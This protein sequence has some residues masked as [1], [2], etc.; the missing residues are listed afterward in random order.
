MPF[1]FLMKEVKET[2]KKITQAQLQEEQEELEGDHKYHDQE[3]QFKAKFDEQASALAAKY[4]HNYDDMPW[5]QITQGVTYIYLILTMLVMFQR[6]DS[7]SITVCTCALY[8]LEFPQFVSR[9]TFRGFVLMIVV[10]WAWDFL[11]LFIFTSAADED[12]EDGGMEYSVRRFSRLFSY[13]SFFFRIIVVAVFWKVSLEFSKIIRKQAPL[14]A[15]GNDEEADL[16]R[17]LAQ[18]EN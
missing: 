4:G 15:S 11:Y 12:E 6:K 13:I 18:Y 10:S 9:Q 14:S 16:E 5:I 2:Q 8:V 1:G 17:I 7:L 3:Q